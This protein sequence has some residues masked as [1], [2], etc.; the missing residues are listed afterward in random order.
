[1]NHPGRGACHTTVLGTPLAQRREGVF[2]RVARVYDHRQL[3]LIRERQACFE[4]LS[5][6]RPWREVPEVVE[7]YFAYCNDVLVH[8]EFA[9]ARK[10]T[11]IRSGRLVW[12]D[13]NRCPD[14]LFA[15]GEFHR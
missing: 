3:Q 15:A 5:L 4:D 1:V 6:N 8:S 13:T 12:M 9:Q 2:H 10:R 11:R 14:A 7:P